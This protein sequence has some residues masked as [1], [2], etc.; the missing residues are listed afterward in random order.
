MEDIN[1]YSHVVSSSHSQFKE[2]SNL[3][4]PPIRNVSTFQSGKTYSNE[5]ESRN[6][7]INQMILQELKEFRSESKDGFE[8][9]EKANIEIIKLQD[10]LREN[11]QTI[12]D[13]LL[14]RNNAKRI[15][16]IGLSTGIASGI[17]GAVLNNFIYIIVGA[18]VALTAIAGLLEAKQNDW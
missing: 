11:T 7:A 9:L 14:A 10:E 2:N 4:L 18:G 13:L 6:D 12:G 5:D 17:G 1:K 8:S 15:Y 16:F 3:W